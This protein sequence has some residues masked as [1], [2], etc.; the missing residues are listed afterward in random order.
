MEGILVRDKI[1]CYKKNII[2]YSTFTEIDIFQKIVIDKPT[3]TF[4]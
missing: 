4:Q 1:A 3:R 2:L